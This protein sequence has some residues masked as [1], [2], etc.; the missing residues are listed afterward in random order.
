MNNGFTNST[1][2]NL[3]IKI[4]S[5]HL[6]DPFSSNPNIGTKKRNK[7]ET[8]NKGNNNFIISFFRKQ[9]GKKIPFTVSKNIRNAVNNICKDLKPK[10]NLKKTILFSPAAASFDQFNNFE[11][12]GNYFKNLIIK[13]FKQ[14]LNV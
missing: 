12:R 13:K 1:G 6:F 5:S 8:I 2:W 10:K 11:N 3:G 14:R 4:K 7:I 9:I